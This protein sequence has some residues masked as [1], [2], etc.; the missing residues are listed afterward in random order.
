MT[1]RLAYLDNLKILLVCGVIALHTAITYGLEGSWYLESYDP[2][3]DAVVDALTVVLGVGWLFGLGLF[4][5]IAGR[6][7]G[8]SYDHKG[9]RRF[10]VERLIRLGIPLLAYTLL[11]GP[12]LLYV[13]H[14]SEA[15]TEAFL[16][17]IGDQIWRLVPG[18]TWFLEALLLFSLGYAGWRLLSRGG[19]EPSRRPLRG[20]QVAALAGAIAAVSF[21][22]RLIFEVGSEQLYLQLAL[23]PQYVVM[24]TLG[25][26]AGRRG[27]LESLQPRL[28]RGCG[29]A[30]LVTVLALPVF[31]L[32]GGFFDDNDPYAGGLHWQAV[33]GPVAEGVLAVCMSLWMVAFSRR[34]LDHQGPIARRMS[35]AAFGA[36][37]IHPPVIVGLALALH[38]LEVPA[39]LKL[40]VVLAAGIAGSFGLAALAARIPPIGRVI[41]SGP[42]AERGDAAPQAP[43]PACFPRRD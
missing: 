31:L 5:L 30:S 19:R 14:R 8:P 24:F 16:P 38:P 36:F 21:C 39:E 7:T 13:E 4:F 32:A 26:A 41:G 1:W 11:I 42:P 29:I 17:F 6:L 2:M 35:P 40:A 3:Q 43:A 23:F 15:G 28:V 20:R 18:P 34:H 25:C 10:T 9:T 37:V 33:I 27:W 22:V 12:V